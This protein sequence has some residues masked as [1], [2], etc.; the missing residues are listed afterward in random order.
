MPNG[1]DA[2]PYDPSVT[3]HG[4]KT[5]DPHN[6]LSVVPVTNPVRGTGLNGTPADEYAVVGARLERG[7]P[8]HPRL[9]ASATT[10]LGA[11]VRIRGTLRTAGGRPIAGARVQ[12]AERAAGGS[13]HLTV[14]AV[15]GG[16]GVAALRTRRGGVN[17]RLR[18]VY[19][20]RDGHD[21]NRGSPVLRL[22]VR[23]GATL[24]LSRRTL[25]NGGV[26]TFRGRVRGRLTARGARVQV[27]VRL[28]AG[29]STFAKTRARRAGHGRFRVR[30]RFRRT[31]HR[32]A[33][34]FRVRVLPG[35]ARRYV[36]GTSRTRR[37]VV[38]P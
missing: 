34:R 30:Y 7:S 36:P 38:L 13:W 14:G 27:Q 33:Y 3:E 31:T 19:F 1:A 18:L 25:H 15:T 17:R 8:S 37:V 5:P 23:Q 16:D 29:W 21:A 20:P 4:P 35:E 28:A 24:A 32:T 2:A 9:S 22:S 12:L 26:L 10:T 6:D 11:R